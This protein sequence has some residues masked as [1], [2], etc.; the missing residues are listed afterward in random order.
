ME[1]NGTVVIGAPDS[2]K[3]LYAYQCE[4][5]DKPWIKSRTTERLPPPCPQ[6]LAICVKGCANKGEGIILLTEV[7]KYH[8]DYQPY[9]LHK[10]VGVHHRPYN[11]RN[12]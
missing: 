1:S 5:N 4:E 6:I 2:R 10:R 8:E 7:T 12:W 3:T 11:S 9:T